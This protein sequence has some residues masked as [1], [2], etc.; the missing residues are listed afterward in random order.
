MD[1]D[2]EPHDPPASQQTA[3]QGDP[4]ELIQLLRSCALFSGLAES[5]L[6]RL[7]SLGQR[8]E[9]GRNEF[10]FREGDDGTTIYL[11]L[12]GAVRISRQ[13]PGMGEEALTV[14]RAG[15]AFGEMALIDGSAR[16]A[17]ALGHEHTE[18]FVLEGTE[19]ENLMFLDRSL[20]TE[21][22]WKLVRQLSLRLRQTN[23]KMT[24]LSVTGRF[25]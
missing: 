16:S 19:L 7:C 18:L 22:L 4:G 23:D 13:V 21:I 20:A 2:H 12:S 14:L 17:D 6:E 1:K 24:L 8:V 25:E 5:Q 9:L 15:S 3:A 11:V 10:L